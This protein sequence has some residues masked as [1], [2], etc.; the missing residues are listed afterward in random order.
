VKIDKYV[1]STKA[2]TNS[3][4]C[5]RWCLKEKE[6]GDY[7]TLDPAEVESVSSSSSVTLNANGRNCTCGS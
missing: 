7:A 6:K 2:T 1:K 3:S 5:C 4:G